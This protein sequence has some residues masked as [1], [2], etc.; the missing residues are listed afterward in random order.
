MLGAQHA[1][2]HTHD[3][4]HEQQ[5]RID[6]GHGVVRLVLCEQATPPRFRLYAQ[7]EHA[8][9]AAQVRLETERADGTRQVFDFVPRAGYLE[10]AQEFPEP[11]E[12]VARLTL[13]HG[14]HRHDYDVEFVEHDHQHAIGDYAGLDVSA[15]GYQDPHELAHA[16]DIRHRFANR[17][18]TT[19]QILMFGFTG[20]L[21]PCPAS[22]TVL[23]V[24]LQLKRI[25]L[26]VTLVLSFSVGLALTMV[27]SGAMAALGVK[28]LSQRLSG[29][30]VLAARAPYVSGALILA[31]GLYLGYE[32]LRALA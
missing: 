24:C 23:L 10:S 32:G 26:G 21:T 4:Q 25:A 22:I 9:S 31:L 12:F 7:G 28:H 30:G 16:N 11:H 1:H 3:H 18:V 2:E 14:S 29:F 27:A 20:G 5:R 17:Q 8:W 15:P 19:G 6:T 13:T